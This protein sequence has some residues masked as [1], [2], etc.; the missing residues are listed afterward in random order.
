MLVGLTLVT[1]RQ[2]L[3]NQRMLLRLL[4]P[5]CSCCG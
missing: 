4:H 2:G 1:A 3:L 5:L